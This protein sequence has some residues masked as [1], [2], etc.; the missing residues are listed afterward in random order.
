[1]ATHFLFI[2]ESGNA[3]AD[4]SKTAKS[5]FVLGGIA[6]PAD[7]WHDI[8]RELSAIKA[9]YKVVDELKFS[10]FGKPPGL[11]GAVS[12][13]GY[14]QRASLRVE[15]CQVI[16]RRNS[17]VIIAAIS[18]AAQYALHGWYRKEQDGIYI[19]GLKVLSERFQYY[20]QD[21][22]RATGSNYTGVLVCDARSRKG[23]QALREA[24]A[25]LKKPGMAYT[26]NY[27]RIVEGL[28]LA[29]SHLSMGLQ[30]ADIVAGAIARHEITSSDPWYALI[31]SRIRRSP[32]G[33]TE[34]FGIVRKL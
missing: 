9:R 23:D 4:A 27:D 31:E 19:G 22:S 6:I 20:L 18:T 25:D 32:A 13:L 11:G 34:G 29:E 12:H 21:L 28:F 8:D 14:E 10:A 15:L 24:F 5:P 1:M 2:D 30:L 3:N 26:S 17:I 33:K 7:I 16:A